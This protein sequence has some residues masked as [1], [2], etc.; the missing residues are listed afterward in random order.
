MD[1]ETLKELT[2]K[3]IPL[4]RDIITAYFSEAKKP[5][6]RQIQAAL[7][8]G[9]ASFLTTLLNGGVDQQA[10]KVAFDVGRSFPHAVDI[11]NLFTDRIRNPKR[12]L[13]E[14][15]SCASKLIS[16]AAVSRIPEIP[17]EERN[18]IRNDIESSL[19]IFS[20]IP[21]DKQNGKG[22]I[23]GGINIQPHVFETG[24]CTE[25]LIPNEDD[26][27][28]SGSG[29]ND[30]L[31]WNWGKK[32]SDD[33][34]A[35][36]PPTL[37]PPAP[38]PPSVPEPEPQAAPVN[39]LKSEDKSSGEKKGFWS[40]VKQFLPTLGAAGAG[41]VLLALLPAPVAQGLTPLYYKTLET[42]GTM[43]WRKS[44]AV[45]K[46]WADDVIKNVNDNSPWYKRLEKFIASNGREAVKAYNEAMKDPEFKKQ[47]EKLQ[48]TAKLVIPAA[49]QDY[50]AYRGKKKAFDLKQ[51]QHV[52][53]MKEKRLR[54]RA[55]AIQKNKEITSRNDYATEVYNREKDIHEKFA[56]RIEI[57]EGIARTKTL[58]NLKWE[59][60]DYLVNGGIG[61]AKSIATIAVSAGRGPLGAL[62][63]L[64]ASV[65]ASGENANHYIGLADQAQALGNMKEMNMYRD[66]AMSSYKAFATDSQILADKMRQQK[67]GMI[68]TAETGAKTLWDNIS[69]WLQAREQEKELQSPE[70]IETQKQLREL[71][72][73]M[74]PPIKPYQEVLVDVPA[75]YKDD[76]PRLKLPIPDDL[77]DTP[78][79]RSVMP[80]VNNIW[81]GEQQR[82]KEIPE[83]LPLPYT[84]SLPK[85]VVSPTSGNSNTLRTSV[86]AKQ[87]VNSRYIQ[88][89]SYGYTTAYSNM[90]P[91]AYAKKTVLPVGPEFVPY[92]GMYDYSMDESKGNSGVKRRSSK[93]SSIPSKKR[94]Y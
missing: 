73:N 18:N 9:I 4:S 77:N 62:G 21:S 57:L 39:D 90:Y 24:Y 49:T 59:K 2:E 28:L 29:W 41:A 38:E 69:G 61:V 81:F 82:N 53:E 11:A 51:Q 12:K 72:P 30:W 47:I 8:A 45:R 20:L 5:A 84:T 44:E 42:L 52:A 3:V 85:T 34:P 55:A 67:L 27:M 13:D 10:Y 40:V 76:D 19:Q 54:E 25:W 1:E 35:P 78:Y 88:P 92:T 46:E 37:E 23:K 75:E 63:G 31:P 89:A 56:K 26:S 94:K 80:L 70:Y 17:D 32:K 83:D 71:D 6:S 14:T 15:F 36:E 74:L 65:I 79:L 22:K 66:K 7:F 48:E 86:V 50:I 91:N 58:K 60:L 16:K 33:E 93:K 68:N 87:G 64:A 43:D